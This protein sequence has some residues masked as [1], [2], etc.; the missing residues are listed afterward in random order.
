[1]PNSRFWTFDDKSSDTGQ[2]VSR[3]SNRYYNAAHHGVRQCLRERLV[4]TPNP[5]TRGRTLSQVSTLIV[6]DTSGFTTLIEPANSSGSAPT[7][8]D[9]RHVRADTRAD[10]LFLAPTLSSVEESDP[11]E[12]VDFIKDDMAAMVWGVERT[13][14]GPLDLAWPGYE[15]YLLNMKANPRPPAPSPSTGNDIAYVLNTTVPYNWIPFVPQQQGNGGP[16]I[17]RRG[18]MLPI[19]P[20]K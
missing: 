8:G 12:K 15:S 3:Q 13:L 6:T 17:L 9:V 18:S 2:L 1:M 5:P 7:H 14:F 16:L 19:R 20:D 11:I 4:P 10:L